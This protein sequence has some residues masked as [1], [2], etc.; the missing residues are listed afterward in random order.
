VLLVT[1]KNNGQDKAYSFSRVTLNLGGAPATI[2]SS[3][4]K[5]LEPSSLQVEEFPLELSDADFAANSQVKIDVDYGGRP[6]FLV[7]K[8]EFTMPLSKEGGFPVMLVVGA[9]GLLV[10]IIIIAAAIFFVMGKKKGKK[11]SEEQEPETKKRKK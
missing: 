10:I 7:K 2:T 8:G 3:G 1:L 6:G 9:V 4:T 11:E 5:T